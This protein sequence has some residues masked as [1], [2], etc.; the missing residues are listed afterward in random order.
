LDWT[1]T[2]G[3]TVGSDVTLLFIDVIG[4][5]DLNREHGRL[6]ADEVLRHVVKYSRTGLRVADILFRYGSDEFV[7]L[8]NR[9]DVA[10]AESIALR[11]RSSIREYELVLRDGNSLEVLTDIACVSSPADGKSLR[12]LIGSARVRLSASAVGHPSHTH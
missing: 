10:T 6:A 12:D 11:I 3:L 8:L 1:G 2:D 4:L 5:E 9:T 7:A